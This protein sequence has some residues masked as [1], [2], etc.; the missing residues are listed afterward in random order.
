MSLFREDWEL[1]RAALSCHV[2]PGYVVP[3]NARGLCRWVAT[4]ACHSKES[5]SLTVDGLW[6]QERDVVRENLK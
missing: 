4:E 3:G 6:Q 5:L 2:S 1:A